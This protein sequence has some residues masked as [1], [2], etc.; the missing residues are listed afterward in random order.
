MS[1]TE[2]QNR[3]D[4]WIS[5]FEEGYF[6][7]LTNMARLAE[8]TGKTMTDKEAYDIV[9]LM[10]DKNADLVAVHKEASS[11]TVDNQVKGNSPL[12]WHPGAVK[13]FNEKGAKL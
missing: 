11:F 3:V 5:Q 9:K 8:E 10:V 4:R 2:A 13:F 7:P 1:L 12:P 6:D